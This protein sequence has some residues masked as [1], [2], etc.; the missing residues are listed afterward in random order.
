MEEQED[1]GAYPHEKQHISIRR[2]LSHF[3]WSWFECTMS[4]GA[5]AVLLSLQPFHFHGLRTI[6]KIFF[7]VDLVLFVLFTSLISFRFFRDPSALKLSLHH[8]HESFFFGTFWV[9]IAMILD[10]V[11]HYGVPVCGPWLL[12]ALEICFWV[13]AACALQVAIFQY[14]VIFDEESLPVIDA[15]PAWIL[16]LYP[17]L[18]LG[19]LAS[20][21]VSS[22]PQTSALPIF[23]GGIV[24]QG[25]GWM[26]AFLIYSLYLTRLINSELP[27]EPKRPAMYIAV[28]P[29]A[30]TCSTL[31]KLGMQ[32]PKVIPAHYLGITTLP[33]GDV[34]KAISV[35]CGLFLWLLGFWF[36]ALS[37]VSVLAG[38]RRIHFTLDCWA[39]I[40]PNAGLTIAAIQIGDVLDSDGI[41]AVGSAMTIILV[42]MW[43][44][45]VVMNVR[46]VW[47]RQVLWPGMD[48]DM[49]DVSGHGQAEVKDD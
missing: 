2:R 19:P 31:I 9:S 36:F 13:Y 27:E 8:P 34:W 48:E 29:A 46:A 23:I 26:F 39:F 35:P 42:A 3:T 10:C 37:T 7:I 12:K 17:F 14:H 47:L 16:P 38:V 33:V 41:K 44:F 5:I 24:F 6:G 28:G 32:A 40:F 49:E 21:L 45:V 18:V 1:E 20:V 30:Y 11:Q 25:L 43:L 4:T 15:M 22:Q